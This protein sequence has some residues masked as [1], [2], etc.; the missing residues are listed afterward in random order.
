MTASR[1]DVWPLLQSGDYGT[2]LRDLKQRQENWTS[3]NWRESGTMGTVFLCLREYDEAARA[4]E[5]ANRMACDDQKRNEGPLLN[6]LGG[7]LWL[8]GS[9]EE[10]AAIWQRMVR[11]LD[12]RTIAWTDLSGGIKSGLLLW[13]AGVTLQKSSAIDSSVKFLRKASKRVWAKSMPGP[14]AAHVIAGKPMKAILAEVWGGSG[15]DSLIARGAEDVLLRRQLCE[16]LLCWATSERLAGRETESR[17]LLRLCADMINPLVEIEWFLAR[18][19]V[20]LN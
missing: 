8:A 5:A 4:F 9:K 2:A 18:G 20:E 16:V 1:F 7:A 10:G 3:S 17:R 14:L 6:K 11:G 19:E 12:D 13:Y 15:L